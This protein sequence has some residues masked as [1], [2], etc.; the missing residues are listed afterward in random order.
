MLALIFGWLGFCTTAKAQSGLIREVYLNVFGGTVSALTNS[1]NFPGAPDIVDTIPDF[2]TPSDIGDNYGQ[3]VH[4]YINIPTNGL[5]GSYTFWIG[6]DDSSAL[7][8]SPDDQAANRVEIASVDGFT[9]SHEYNKFPSQQ[10]APITL[11]AGHRYYIEAL[12]VE[13]GGSDHLEVRWQLPD[14][15][16]EDPIPNSRLIAELIPPQISRQPLSIRATEGQSATFTVQLVNRGPIDYQWLRN[17]NII[18]GATNQTYT[19]PSVKFSDN[20][21][22]FSVILTNSFG[23]RTSQAAILSVDRDVTPPSLLFVSNQGES[24]FVTLIFSKPLSVSSA[25]DIS[26]YQLSGG[27][28]VV[29]AS[30]SAD[31]QTVILHTTPLSTSGTYTIGVSVG[32][33]GLSDRA[34]IPNVMEPAERQFSLETQPLDVATLYGNSENIGPSSRRTGLIIS[35]IMYHPKNRPDGRN[36]EFIELY[37]SQENIE[38]LGGYSLSGTVNYTFPSG[39]FI[40][41]GSYLVVAP[42]PSDVQVVYGLPRVYGGFPSLLSNGAGTIR[43]K[44]SQG[45]VLLEVHYDSKGAWPIA[46]DGAGHSLVLARP[47]YGEGDPRAWA[48]S[49]SMGGSPGRAEVKVSNPFASVVINEFLA[50]TDDPQRDFIELFNNSRQPV[51]LSGCFLSDSPSTNKFRIPAGTIIPPRGFASFDQVALGFGLQALG[52]SI[53][54]VNSQSNRVI[55]AIRFEAQPNGVSSGRFPDGAPIFKQLAT[56]TPGTPNSRPFHAPVVINELMY[57]PISGNDNDQFIELYN[58]SAAAVDLSGWKLSDGVD[59]TFPPNTTLASGGFIVVARDEVHL[60]GIY[61]NLTPAN[62]VGNFN[63]SLSHGGERL[64][65]TRPDIIQTTNNAG[66]PTILHSFV[67]VDEVKFGDGGRWGKWS[68][69]GGSSLELIDPQSDNDFASNWADSDESRKSGWTTIERTGYVN[70]GGGYRPDALDVLMQGQAEAL[71]DNVQVT[72][73]SVDGIATNLVANGTFDTG[74]AGW[75]A[76]GTHED[77]TWEPQDGKPRGSLHIRATARGD[78]SSNRLRTHLSKIPATNSIVTMRA[79]ARWLAGD[80]EILLR[81]HGNWLEAAGRLQVPANLGTPGLPNSRLVTNSGPSIVRVTHTPVLPGANQDARVSAY[82]SDE[83][84]VALVRLNYRIDPS[85]NVQQLLMDYN[86]A[87]FY[88]AAIP[89]QPANVGVAFWVDAV[90]STGASARFPNDAPARE[91]VVRFGELQPTGTFGTYHL[92]LNQSNINYWTKRPASSNKGIDA[93]FAYNNDR[94]VYN[95]QTLYSGSPFHWQ[96]YNGPLGNDA[97]YLMLFPSDDLFLG[98]SDFVLNEPGNAGSRE[99]TSIHEQLFYWMLNELGLPYTYR[100]FMNLTINGQRRNSSGLIGAFEDAQQPNS[101]FISEWFPNDSNGELFKIEDWFEFNDSSGN[102]FNQDATLDLFTST[103]LLTGQIEKKLERYRWNF[104]KRATDSAND[105]SN[106]FA[107]VDAVNTVPAAEYTQRVEQLVDIDEWMRVIAL[108]HMASDWDSYGYRRGKNMYAY[109]PQNGKWV[110]LNWDVAFAFGVGDGPQESVFDTAHSDGTIDKITDRMLKHPPF[111]RLYLRALKE[112]ADGPMLLSRYSP[113]AEAKHAALVGNGITQDVSSPEDPAALGI[114]LN[115]WIEQRRQYLLGVASAGDAAFA[116]TS[117]GGSNFSTNRNQIT[118]TGTAPLAVEYITINGVTYPVTWTAVNSWSAQIALPSATNNIVVQGL[119]RKGNAI[120][121]AMDTITVTYSGLNDKPEDKVVFNEIMYNPLVPNTEFIE[122][123]NISRTVAFDLSGFELHGVDFTFPA[124]VII[125]PG[126]FSLVVK[127]LVAFTAK[128][129]SGLPVA[130]EYAGHLDPD[131]ETLTLEKPVSGAGNQVID[132]VRYEAAT[133]WPTVANGTGASLQV[134]DPSRDT[135]RVGNWS[136]Q[137]G[138]STPGSTN[139]IRAT[140]TAFPQVWVNEL[141]ANNTSGLLNTSGGRSPWIELYNSSS[142][143]ANLSGLYLTDNTSALSKWAFPPNT[144]IAPK[145]FLVVRADGDTAQSTPAELHTNFRLNPTNGFAA[146]AGLQG[147]QQ[148]VY[149]YLSYNG[150]AADH[151]FGAYPDGQAVH[152][153]I[154]SLTTPGATNNATGPSLAVVINE[155][156]AANTSTV[157]DP[158]TK[159][160]DDWFELYNGGT[161][162]ADLS[163]YTLT[164][165]LTNAS[166]ITIPNGVQIPA[167][168]YLLVWADG[169]ATTLT[170]GQLHVKF[171]L[172]QSGEEIGLFTPSGVLVDGVTFGAQTNDVS[173]GRIPNGASGPYSFMV[174]ATPGAANIGT[175]SGGLRIGSFS[176]VSGSF[177]LS[178]NSEPGTTYQVQSRTELGA[179]A[180]DTAATVQATSSTTTYTENASA[181]HKFYRIVK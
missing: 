87:G 39:A 97:N 93:T 31:G 7:Y 48:A 84:R 165:S 38:N 40:Q 167:G 32:I 46:P 110:L 163:G 95:M 59:F 85:T 135:S 61:N 3:R 174:T 179:G 151:S 17:G 112:A 154:F 180:W 134:I 9:G 27:A 6:S 146:L 24:D 162:M 81:L 1:A 138:I 89:G 128:Y 160:Y 159:K 120:T 75:L 42:S 119:D 114:S 126:G 98:N 66:A 4:G 36:L 175:A 91:C 45:A 148:V 2:E 51:D 72:T 143:T 142:A 47:S 118:L 144:T 124:G 86:G 105:Y 172:A 20:G 78:T 133:P 150:L 35:E 88:S 18:P 29:S 157:L 115:D 173:E 71:L 164:D 60:R 76:Q 176:I 44:N 63:G 103:N 68:D 25:T 90:D 70:L 155:W 132:A 80:P 149:D 12:Q 153:Q 136:A 170:N 41:P 58:R 104:R 94:V 79:E 83:D 108:R 156:M 123:N 10:S 5:S 57:H 125:P 65:L 145:Q 139:S 166:Q 23:T 56:V 111:L 67:L 168:A 28:E 158:L 137:S 113:F 43:L 50:H 171:K 96:G 73:N 121:S 152:R 122:L 11:Q 106:L 177:R 107:L 74:I 140:L 131:G 54:F 161:T 53:F 109:K 19:I 26:N 116:L 77:S 99:P 22:R 69:G 100:R 55:D 30:L 141:V 64:A 21:A 52:E 62:T 15:T 130:G 34:D 147:G 16:I 102:R 117:N 181:A 178:W 92:W 129:G 169:E 13:G 37:N 82:I 127:D 8:L 101:D 49:E 14:G 33:D